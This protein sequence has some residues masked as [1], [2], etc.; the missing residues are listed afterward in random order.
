MTMRFDAGD[1]Q[2][3]AIANTIRRQ[4]G[5]MSFAQVGASDLRVVDKGLTFMARLHYA[6]QSRVL[7]MRVTVVL[8]PAD[9]YTVTVTRTNKW[10]A[11]LSEHEWENVYAD[12]LAGLI[13]SFDLEGVSNG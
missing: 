10:G 9:T 12:Q 1:G 7:K 11:V 13:Q 6:H 3:L 8:A 2:D 4:M 5:V